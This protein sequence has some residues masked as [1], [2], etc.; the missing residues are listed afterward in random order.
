[1]VSFLKQLITT[2]THCIAL[3]YDGGFSERY[4]SYRNSI[5]FIRF[6]RRSA[7]VQ[8]PLP[9]AERS[10]AITFWYVS[11]EVMWHNFYIKPIN[12][13]GLTSKWDQISIKTAH[14][15]IIPGAISQLREK[16]TVV[17]I[18]FPPSIASN[19]KGFHLYF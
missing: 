19:F 1:M 8:I 5:C 11:R 9:N 15:F 6:R 14:L 12:R 4:G 3:C 10:R 16:S 2:I 7:S 18:I 17:R 13:Q